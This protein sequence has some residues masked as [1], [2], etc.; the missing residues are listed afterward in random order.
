[1]TPDDFW[2]SPMG[3]FL[4]LRECHLHYIGAA[5]PKQEL[6]IDGIIPFGL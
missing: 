5:K 3:F 2:G 6:D 1:M 4:D